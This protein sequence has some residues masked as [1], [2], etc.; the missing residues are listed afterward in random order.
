MI[1][2][3]KDQIDYTELYTNNFSIMYISKS[4]S[5][6]F[7]N[8]T[9]ILNYRVASEITKIKKHAVTIKSMV[10]FSLHDFLVF[11]YQHPNLQ[12]ILP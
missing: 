10:K 6:I 11:E 5:D 7:Y 3:L 9:N 1:V 12:G 8:R 2:R 4:S